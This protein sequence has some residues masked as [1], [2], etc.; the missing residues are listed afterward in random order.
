MEVVN[1][2]TPSKGP[3]MKEEDLRVLR[4]FEFCDVRSRDEIP[5]ITGLTESQVSYSITNLL[6]DHLIEK[7]K[8]EP[9]SYRIREE[10]NERLAKLKYSIGAT[11]RS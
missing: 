9:D 1:P 7:S 8:E 11:R 3:T 2:K 4:T 5:R 10:G 6:F